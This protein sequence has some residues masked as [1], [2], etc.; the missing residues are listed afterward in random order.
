MT[1]R[2]LVLGGGGVAG[3][4]WQ[5]GVLLGL[6]ESGADVTDAESLAA[7]RAGKK[8]RK[9]ATKAARASAPE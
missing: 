3:I 2:A 1:R 7:V 6:A 8:E 9:A 5:T 4:A